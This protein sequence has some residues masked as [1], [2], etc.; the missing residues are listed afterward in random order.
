M[1]K[2]HATQMEELYNQI[3]QQEQKYRL[4]IDEVAAIKQANSELLLNQSQ[5]SQTLYEKSK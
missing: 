4:K 2:L 3:G 1:E 5:F